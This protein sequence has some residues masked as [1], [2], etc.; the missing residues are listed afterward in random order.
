LLTD[1]AFGVPVIPAKAGIP[2]HYH[3]DMVGRIACRQRPRLAAVLAFYKCQPEPKPN[4]IAYD[5][6]N[7]KCLI[8][9]RLPDIS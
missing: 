3:A 2:F 7:N 5:E 4:K 1:V 9:I 6:V 8:E